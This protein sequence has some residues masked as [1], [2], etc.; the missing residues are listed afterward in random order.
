ML[1]YV[2]V[3]DISAEEGEPSNFE[4]LEG[5]DYWEVPIEGGPPC[6]N[7][8]P[9]FNGTLYNGGAGTAVAG[10]GAAP[11][12]TSPAAAAPGLAAPAPEDLF[13]ENGGDYLGGPVENGGHPAGMV[14]FHRMH[15]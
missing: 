5:V 12:G 7:P 4:L 10:G 9:A 1:I 2:Q 15:D 6:D 11:G 13:R 8:V 3:H 14:S